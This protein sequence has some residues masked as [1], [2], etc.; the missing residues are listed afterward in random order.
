MP[1]RPQVFISLHRRDAR[2]A[3]AVA[4]RLRKA[5]IPFTMYKPERLWKDGLAVT[6]EHL[7]AAT[8]VIYVGSRWTRSPWV[9]IERDVVKR[10]GTPMLFIR[11]PAQIDATVQAV[12]K[13]DQR[14]RRVSAREFSQI[15]NDHLPRSAYKSSIVMRVAGQ[16]GPLDFK[17][18]FVIGAFI[19]TVF[20]FGL[21][22]L[23]A[24]MSVGWFFE[25]QSLQQIA[26]LV[27][28][29]WAIGGI[30]SWGWWRVQHRRV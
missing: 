2:L 13:L 16:A 12:T 8:C 28:V 23:V 14:G 1:V 18:A 24:L 3:S 30:A 11:K 19:T 6:R 26:H 20:V 15:V 17:P 7:N 29:L 27:L 21:L 4:D 25:W 22:L 10:S 9:L 5:R